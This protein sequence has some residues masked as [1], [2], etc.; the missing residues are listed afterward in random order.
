MQKWRVKEKYRRTL[1][2]TRVKNMLKIGGESYE[3][4]LKKQARNYI[5]ALKFCMAVAIKKKE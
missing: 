1:N 4:L 5:R 2:N 3:P